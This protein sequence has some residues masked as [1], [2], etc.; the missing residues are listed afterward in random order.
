MGYGKN[1]L[2]K[3]QS[4]IIKSDGVSFILFFRGVGMAVKMPS[5]GLKKECAAILESMKAC[6]FI[7]FGHF[8]SSGDILP[9]F[10]I[11]LI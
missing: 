2:R 11:S 5:R 8:F 4:S 3:M 1:V 9:T 10:W 7:L 6:Y